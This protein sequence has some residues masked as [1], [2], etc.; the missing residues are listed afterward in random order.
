MFCN[1]FMQTIRSLFSMV[2][3]KSRNCGIVLN[4]FVCL[5]FIDINKVPFHSWVVVYFCSVSFCS[6]HSSAILFIW[7]DWSPSR[8]I[9]AL[10][11]ILDD[12]M[13]GF[14]LFALLWPLEIA[15]HACLMAHNAGFLMNARFKYLVEFVQ[16]RVVLF[17]RPSMW[18][19]LNL[20]HEF[21][22]DRNHL[23]ISL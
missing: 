9:I 18:F 12:L 8:K 10:E 11:F 16:C 19:L 23:F 17:S 2:K 6:P 20:L 5:S 4:V 1:L 3:I 21:H 14:C 7:S 15:L 22:C 13:S